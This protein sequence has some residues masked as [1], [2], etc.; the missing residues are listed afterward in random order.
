MCVAGQSVVRGQK[1]TQAQPGA[2]QA[3]PGIAPQGPGLVP[4]GD[5]A[6]GNANA[7]DATVAAVGANFLQPALELAQR[8]L[9]EL[10]S[11]IKDYTDPLPV[12]IPVLMREMGNSPRGV[13]EGGA[14]PRP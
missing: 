11:K 2:I 9:G 6:Q 5:V 7:G 13:S 4:N 3:Q 12:S 1:A 8:G 10:R 14:Q